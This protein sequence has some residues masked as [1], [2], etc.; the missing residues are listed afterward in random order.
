MNTSATALPFNPTPF[1]PAAPFPPRSRAR[2]LARSRSLHHLFAPFPPSRPLLSPPHPAASGC[3]AWSVS[4]AGGRC[5]LPRSFSSA[6][7][8]AVNC[9]AIT[10]SV[11]YTSPSC[12]ASIDWL[13][14]SSC[15]SY[16]FDFVMSILD[17]KKP[18]Y[19]KVQ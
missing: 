19:L 2:S 17:V 18:S 11:A 9:A 14:S 16:K 5:L 12:A 8:V 1:L 6:A 13:H 15:S 4:I 7:F 3:A 10:I